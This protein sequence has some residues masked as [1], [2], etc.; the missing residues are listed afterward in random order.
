MRDRITKP[1]AVA[2]ARALINIHEVIAHGSPQLYPCNFGNQNLC[3][4]PRS[5]TTQS[6]L[7]Q[8]N[9]KRWASQRMRRLFAPAKKREHRTCAI[10]SPCLGTEKSNPAQGISK[11][12]CSPDQRIPSSVFQRER[13]ETPCI[14]TGILQGQRRK[15]APTIQ[16]PASTKSRDKT[17]ERAQAPGA[18]TGIEDWP[19]SYVRTIAGETGTPM[20]QLSTTGKEF[21]ISD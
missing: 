20:R 16:D 18:K 8:Q 15:I 21:E 13:R 4:L 7:S 9:D 3:S 2:P 17:T 6:F 12:E 10:P 5:E 1:V 14:P 19:D 11:G